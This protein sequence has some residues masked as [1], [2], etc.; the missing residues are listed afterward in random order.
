MM[1]MI[2]IMVIMMMTIAM[3]VMMGTKSHSIFFSIAPLLDVNGDSGHDDME[4]NF[5]IIRCQRVE[6]MVVM[7]KMA[8]TMI[9][10]TRLR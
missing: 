2:M 5:S 3:M 10:K 6:N 4:I 9:I 8:V 7:V 1:L